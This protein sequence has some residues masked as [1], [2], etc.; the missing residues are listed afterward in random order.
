MYLAECSKGDPDVCFPP[1]EEPHLYAIAKRICE[2]CPV[3]GFCLEIGLDEKWGMW[4]GLD[5]IERAKLA[6][7]PKLPKDRLERRRFLRVYAYT[8]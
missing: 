2:E 8:N 5:P 3:S 1:D 6:K 4:G 7:S